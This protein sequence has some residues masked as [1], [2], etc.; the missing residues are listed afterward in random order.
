MVANKGNTWPPL[1]KQAMTSSTFL[2][3]QY[4][5]DDP[6]SEVRHIHFAYVSQREF[7]HEVNLANL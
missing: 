6:I 1:F 4:N 7:T 2:P 5:Y 3:S